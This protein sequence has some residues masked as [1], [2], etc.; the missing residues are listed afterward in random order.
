MVD[1]EITTMSDTRT[2]ECIF[3]GEHMEMPEKVK[4]RKENKQD[5]ESR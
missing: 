1:L 5:A 3:C 4:A 2:F